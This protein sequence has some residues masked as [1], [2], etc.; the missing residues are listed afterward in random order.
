[1]RENPAPTCH[2]AGALKLIGSWLEAPTTN[3][4]TQVPNTRRYLTFAPVQ[5]AGQKLHRHGGPVA[6]QHNVELTRVVVT[7][8]HA[9]LEPAPNKCWDECEGRF[10]VG[11]EIYRGSDGAACVL[12]TAQHLCLEPVPHKCWDEC[13]QV[14]DKVVQAAGWTLN[15]PSHYTPAITH[16]APLSCPG[17]FHQLLPCAVG[18]RSLYRRWGRYTYRARLSNCLGLPD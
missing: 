16:H 8:H 1:M 17:P 13:E 18:S 5:V 9:R 4:L 6:G 10:K 3:L 7:A 2:T 14:G 12:F 15:S 11:G